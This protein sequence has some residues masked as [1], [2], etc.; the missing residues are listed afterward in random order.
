MTFRVEIEREPDGRW[1]ADVPSLPG[2]MCYAGDRNEALA[3]VQA[4]AL[5]VIAERLEQRET[6][7]E[8][9]TVTFTAS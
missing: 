9:L 6:P 5:R 4:L 7:G 2:V 1:L 3:K 8:L